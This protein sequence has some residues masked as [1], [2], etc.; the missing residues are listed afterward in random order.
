MIVYRSLFSS[1]STEGRTVVEKM[2]SQLIESGTE[3]PHWVLTSFANKAKLRA[4][5]DNPK[6][7]KRNLKKLKYRSLDV[8]RTHRV[9]TQLWFSS[10]SPFLV[11]LLPTFD[12]STAKRRLKK[13]IFFNILCLLKRYRWEEERER[14]QKKKTKARSALIQVEYTYVTNKTKV[15]QRPNVC[16]TFEHHGVQGIQMT[17]VKDIDKMDTDMVEYLSNLSKFDKKK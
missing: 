9:P 7:L 6:N 5:T 12:F 15:L 11:L 16:Y 3:I 13:L 14:G 4:N 10:P 17:S 1:M 2:I 8:C